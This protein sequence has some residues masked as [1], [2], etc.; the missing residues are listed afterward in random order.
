MKKYY[1]FLVIGSGLAGLSY[2]L[3]VAPHGKVAIISKTKLEET[4]TSYAQGGIAAVTHKP[5]SYNKHIQDTLTAGDGLCDEDIVRLVVEEAPGQIDE[6]IRWGAQF[7]RENDG[8]FDLAREGGHSEHRILHHKDNTGSEI[9]RAL[10]RQARV[11]KNIDIFQEFFAVDIITQHHLGKL[12]KRAHT[13]TECYGVYA[14]DLKKHETITILSRVSLI[15]TGG[16]GNLY[17][18]TT[19]P[20]I[21]T[22]DG[23]AMVYR[24]KGTVE[25]MEFVQFHPTA[26]YHPGERPSFL[27]TEAMRGFG[28]ILENQRGVQFMDKYDQRGSLA[29]RDIV[30]RAIDNEL[31]VSGDEFVYLNCTHLEAKALKE[32]FPTIY[33]KCQSV[34]I[35]ITRN[36]IPV[37]P[38]AHYLCGGIKVNNWG[39]TWINRLYAA[40]ET[41][42]TGLHGANRLASNSLIEAIVFA[43]RAAKDSIQVY[44]NFDHQDNIPDW[45]DE[46]TRHPEEMVLI[47]Q[48]FKEVQQ[49]FTNYVGIVR[50]NLRLHRALVR[51]EII[52]METEE[53]FKKS[54]LSKPLCELRNI[55]NVGYL[56]IKMAQQ[57]TESKGLHYNVDFPKAGEPLRLV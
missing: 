29:P 55:I 40:G 8:R 24:A 35:D 32:H 45:N 52:Y 48:N 6:L 44:K 38:A 34:G 2:A 5:D 39:K 51:L 42:S 1:D 41:A 56:I 49:I 18:T 27:I 9:Q 57:R 12:V 3:K 43:D 19:N 50:S 31:K 16:T 13:D 11:H 30:A 15:A 7:D 20:P 4:N 47:T 28:A 33:K 22:G 10:S 23:I 37:V 54:T 46:G 21:A 36:K 53:L 26:L 25:N 17:S 14:F